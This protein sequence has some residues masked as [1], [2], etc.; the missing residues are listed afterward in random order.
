M[1]KCGVELWGSAKIYSYSS[2]RYR[3]RPHITAVMLNLLGVCFAGP[4]LKFTGLQVERS[5][6]VQLRLFMAFP[7]TLYSVLR[8]PYNRGKKPQ[9][10]LLICM[11]SLL[12]SYVCLCG[13]LYV[14][15]GSWVMWN[16][17]LFFSFPSSHW[18]CLY[19]VS[20]QIKMR[21]FSSPLLTGV[22]YNSGANALENG[23]ALKPQ[24]RLVRLSIMC[25]IPHVC[26]LS[27]EHLELLPNTLRTTRRGSPMALHTSLTRYMSWN[28]KLEFT[29]VLV[30]D[31]RGRRDMSRRMRMSGLVG[32]VSLTLQKANP[33]IVDLILDWLAK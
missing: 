11:C 21:D 2:A 5:G 20:K 8:V 16:L 31:M 32:G 30:R 29:L 6:P 28:W 22:L 14:A 24:L 27:P 9:R 13:K 4:F 33:T 15:I 12:G 23:L 3:S 18:V 26:W 17:F 25:I 1:P 10:G 7:R 19:S